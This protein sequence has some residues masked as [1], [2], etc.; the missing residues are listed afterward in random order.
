MSVELTML[1][2]SVALLVIVIAIQASIA[3]IAQGVAALAGPRDQLG[4]PTVLQART[5]RCVDN[6]R[7]GLLIFAPLVL[8]AAIVDVSTSMTVLGAQLFFFSRVIHAGIYIAGVA[9]IR[10]IFW[11]IG[12]AGCVM[13]FIELI[14]F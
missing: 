14:G 2:Y 11:A 1:L 7:E 13:I 4:E 12:M 10:P 5:K 8:I 9:W 3:I 6:H